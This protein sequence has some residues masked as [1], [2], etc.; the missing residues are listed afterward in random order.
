MI[1]DGLIFGLANL[2]LEVIAI[3]SREGKIERLN[4]KHRFYIFGERA[5]VRALR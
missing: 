2:T 4:V 1:S 3:F 5:R